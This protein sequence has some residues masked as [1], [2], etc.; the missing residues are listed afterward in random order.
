MCGS[1]DQCSVLKSGMVGDLMGF[2]ELLQVDTESMQVLSRYQG[3]VAGAGYGH[4]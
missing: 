2:H 4:G 3:A 1:Q